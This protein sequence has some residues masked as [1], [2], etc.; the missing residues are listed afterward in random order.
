MSG[1]SS[2]S[3]TTSSANSGNLTVAALLNQIS[4]VQKLLAEGRSV[5]ETDDWG[6][7][8]LHAAAL[9]GRLTVAKLLLDKGAD[10]NK[11]NHA[12][13]TPLHKAVVSGN[14][15][16]IE[17]LMQH[18]ADGD[19]RNNAG[20][21]PE[22]YTKKKNLK[23]MVL[24]KSAVEIK[25]VVPRAM[26]GLV[27]GQGGKTLKRIR[28]ASGADVAFP[29]DEDAEEVVIRGRAE[30]T[31]KAREL[32]EEIVNKRKEVEVAVRCPAP[33]DLPHL[34]PPLASTPAVSI[35]APGQ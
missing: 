4:E 17:L 22:D 24:G 25:V 31:E 28:T 7:S 6:D 9:K 5:D 16:L 34:P 35:V 21:L 3:S 27:I 23:L 12:G 33:M 13:S 19:V 18:G 2:S 15:H 30:A 8:A 29:T 26:R 11:T 20:L 32:V 14:A 10:V 1:S